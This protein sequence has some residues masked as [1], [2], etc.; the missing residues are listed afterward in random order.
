MASL[1]LVPPLLADTVYFDGSFYLIMFLLLAFL[2]FSIPFL[3]E[4]LNKQI[5]RV[6][7]L[8]GGWF[9]SGLVIEIFN[10]TIPKI[11]I[12]NNNDKIMYIKV[13][14]CFVIGLFV[15]MSSEIWSKQKS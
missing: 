15:I 5:K 11:I 13:L 9:F 10:L 12:N 1:N 14:V 4:K 3:A 6:S 7:T 2:G 8:I